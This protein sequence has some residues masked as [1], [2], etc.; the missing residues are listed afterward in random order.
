MPFVDSSDGLHHAGGE[1]DRMFI[2]IY[3]VYALD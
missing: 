2:F 1:M 3:G